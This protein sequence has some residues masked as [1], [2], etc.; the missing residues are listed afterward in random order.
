MTRWGRLYGG[1][2]NHRKI[3]ML[4]EKFP[5]DWR[6]WYILIDL[7][8]EVNDDGWIYVSPGVPY[9]PQMLC[10]LLSIRLRTTLESYLN[11]LRTLDLIEVNDRGIKLLSFS[12]R[13][14]ISDNSTIRVRKYREKRE[15]MTE[16]KRFGNV[17]ETFLKRPIDRDRNIDIKHINTPIVP[18]GTS[19]GFDEFWKAYPKKIGKG[20]ALKKWEG[21]KRLHRLPPVELIIAAVENQKTWEQW[22]KDEGQFIPNPAT[23]LNQ[24]R[25]EDQQTEG[26]PKWIQELSKPASTN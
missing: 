22:Q 9:Q 26:G 1:T 18:K 19:N 13:N 25:W 8:I 3:V 10:K 5:S 6:A 17:S 16:K 7:A 14:F 2:Y 21:L 4:R 11:E 15:P 20:A 24:G 12:D 23:W